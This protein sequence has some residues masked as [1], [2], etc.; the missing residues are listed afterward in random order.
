[1]EIGQ[2]IQ[3]EAIPYSLEYF[4]DIKMEMGD[5]GG[6]CDDE[7]CDDEDCHGKDDDDDDDDDA[8]KKK[9]QAKTKGPVK[10][11]AASGD[12]PECK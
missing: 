10:Q 9:K 4:L 8:P 2:I 7:D 1:L 12:K 3:E 11:D 5:L 6:C